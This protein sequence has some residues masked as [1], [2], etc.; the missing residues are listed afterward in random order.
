MHHRPP[1]SREEGIGVEGGG[2]R[3]KGTG[4]EAEGE[5]GEE[6]EGGE[7]GC[8]GDWVF[9]EACGMWN[10]VSFCAHLVFPSSPPPLSCLF[11]FTPI[12]LAL[13]SLSVRVRVSHTSLKRPAVCLN[14]CLLAFSILNSPLHLY[15][16]PPLSIHLNLVSYLPSFFAFIILFHCLPLFSHSTSN[17]HV[18]ISYSCPP[19]SIPVRLSS[20]P[21]HLLTR[22]YPPIHN[23][24]LSIY[25]HLFPVTV[26][27]SI[28]TFTFPRPRPPSSNTLCFPSFGFTSFTPP[29][30]NA[31]LP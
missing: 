14:D 9:E 29:F 17:T 21:S 19:P 20:L 12:Q 2:C 24:Q 13:L 8:E 5:F 30:F 4:V 23:P 11:A 27:I 22:L 25:V 6:G 18:H 15:S 26:Q 7:D 28:S 16:V 1:C 31:R 3:A 10:V